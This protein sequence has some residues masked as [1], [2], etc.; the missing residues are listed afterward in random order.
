M[1]PSL[2]DMLRRYRVQA[3]FSQKSVAE[4][5]G[6]SRSTYTYYETGK[7]SPDP[8]TLFRIAQIFDIPLEQLFHADKHSETVM[9]WDS[10]AKRAPKKAAAD[11]KRAGELTSG[12]KALVAYIRSNNISTER[13]LDVLRRFFDNVVKGPTVY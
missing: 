6:I 11:P 5:L 8:S 7:T 10:G 4:A 2:A 12:E 13:A 9:L 3:G 1:L